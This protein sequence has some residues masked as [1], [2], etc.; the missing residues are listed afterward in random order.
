MVSELNYQGSSINFTS[1]A[2]LPRDIFRFSKRKILVTNARM[3]ILRRKYL[4][5]DREVY[6]VHFPRR[7]RMAGWLLS[8]ILIVSV[9]NNK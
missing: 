8:K 9:Y 4:K 6:G 5:L 3:Q 7:H 2:G 1:F